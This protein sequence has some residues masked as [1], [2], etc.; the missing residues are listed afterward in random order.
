MRLVK[1]DARSGHPELCWEGPLSFPGA[2][3]VGGELELRDSGQKEVISSGRAASFPLPRPYPL[4][5]SLKGAGFVCLFAGSHTVQ[6]SWALQS[7]A[8]P[9]WN[10]LED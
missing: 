3:A 4:S 5:L 2:E 9:R 6:H 7:G 1:A 10:L 8:R